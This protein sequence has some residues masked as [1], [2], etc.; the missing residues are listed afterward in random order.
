[1]QHIA[2]KLQA[3]ALRFRAASYIP[4]FLLLAAASASPDRADDF[5][6]AGLVQF[7]VT[8]LLAPVAG[9]VGSLRTTFGE[10]EIV[11]RLTNVAA[12]GADKVQ[13]LT[14]TSTNQICH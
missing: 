7:K 1:M 4:V 9:N 10:K 11:M 13:E 2:I 3:V 5:R 6:F 12:A 14:T 8:S